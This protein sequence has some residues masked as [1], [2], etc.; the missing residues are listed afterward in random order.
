MQ[1]ALPANVKIIMGHTRFTTQGSERNNYNNHP[2]FG[3]VRKHT[4]TLAHNGILQNDKELR[5]SMKLPKTNIQTDSY[6]AV[7]L[8]ERE[9]YIS[10]D[11][12]RKVAEAVRGSF[13]FTVLD[14]KDNLYF[15]RGDNPLCIYHFDKGFYLYASTEN[16]LQNTLIRLGIEKYAYDKIPVEMGDILMI[17]SDGKMKKEQ[18]NAPVYSAPQ[19]SYYHYPVYISERSQNY[20]LSEDDQYIGML[21][22]ISGLY[23]YTPADIDELVAEGWT[24][25]EIEQILYDESFYAEMAME[26]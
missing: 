13:V 24:H 26:Y 16:I 18:F 21:K 3:R 7:Q 20:G 17:A 10:F 12:L 8:L 4:F 19:H 2:F 5:E 6:I 1:Y 23:G 11:S 25:G 14:S 22:Q 15:I 9:G